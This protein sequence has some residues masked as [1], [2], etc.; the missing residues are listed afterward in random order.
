M[1]CPNC[2]KPI[3]DDEVFCSSCGDNLDLDATPV[4]TSPQGFTPV[5]TSYQ[6]ATPVDTPQKSAALV[7]L[8]PQ[9][10]AGTGIVLSFLLA[11]LGHLYAEQMGKGLGLAIA[12][13]V[14]LT[15]TQILTLAEILTPE[16]LAFA[17]LSIFT[18]IIA[19]AIWLWALFDT[20]NIINRYN[21][22]A[23]KMGNPPW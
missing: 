19:F 3:L 16:S 13:I 22:Y 11:G 6:D 21:E 9:K 14:L 23:R 7:Y 1:Y 8:I 4:N 20:R 10:N 17:L 5:D 12:Y 18:I 15:L 2:G